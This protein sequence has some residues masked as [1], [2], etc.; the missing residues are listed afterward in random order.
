ML[1]HRWRAVALTVAHGNAVG[2]RGREIDVVGAGGG[3]QD[4][5]QLGA[6][7]HGRGIDQ[8]FVADR[9]GGALEMF[10]HLIRQCLGIQLQL[11]EA[12]T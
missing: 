6:R 1:R 11:A 12:V 2:P 9:H 7:R 5:L 10:V 3:D 8:D 4:Q